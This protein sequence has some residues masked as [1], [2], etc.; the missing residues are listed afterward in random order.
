MELCLRQAVFLAVVCSPQKPNLSGKYLSQGRH[1]VPL[2]SKQGWAAGP[3][4][5][6][7]ITG[8]TSPARRRTLSWHR[9]AHAARPAHRAFASLRR[10]VI[11]PVT[12]GQPAPLPAF[13][14]RVCDPGAKVV[15]SAV[16]CDFS[17]AAPS[18]VTRRVFCETQR[19]GVAQR[20]TAR[21]MTRTFT[22][23]AGGREGWSSAKEMERRREGG[24]DE[25]GREWKRGRK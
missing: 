9:R 21:R 25:G 18:Q 10:P 12:H 1:S 4:C 16:A 17:S 20:R 19:S 5:E 23:Q 22:G 3:G 2:A 7:D 14:V 15:P 6:A 11:L 8:L 24:R 13:S